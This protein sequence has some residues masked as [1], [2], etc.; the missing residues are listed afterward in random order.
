MTH[1]IPNAALD[2]RLG[3]IGTSGSGKTY[4][5]GG[6]V[7]RLLAKK[8]RVVIIDPLG[9]RWGLRLSADGKHASPYDAAIF[10]GPRGDLPLNEHAGAL[11]GE[12]AATMAESC[13]VDLRELGTHRAETRDALPINRNQL[14]NKQKAASP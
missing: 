4:N 2:D 9:V 14:P 1:P 11:L 6:A 13:I 12:T 8:A 10:G 5:A 3:F 7:E